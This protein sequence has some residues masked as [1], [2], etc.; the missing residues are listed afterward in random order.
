MDST[1]QPTPSNSSVSDTVS[2]LQIQ[3]DRLKK[4]RAEEEKQNIQAFQKPAPA[5]KADEISAEDILNAFS[6]SNSASQTP[7]SPALA[8]DN[9][10]DSTQAV[11]TAN[12]TTPTTSDSIPD[13]QI[14][15]DQTS[16]PQVDDSVSDVDLGQMAQIQADQNMAQPTGSL[17]KEAIQLGSNE[18]VKYQEIGAELEKDQELEKWVEEIP[19]PK[20]ITLPKPVKDDYGE[21]LVQASQIPKP[22]I[23]LPISED[24]MEKALHYKIIDSIR[25]LY[26]WA[27]RVILSQPNRVYY[28]DNK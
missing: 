7:T 6:Q 11:P 26:E 10:D 18:M 8:D 4:Q 5:I 12:L 28:Q 15:D 17:R 24:Q 1:A 25:W 14:V 23:I 19:D 3:L 27:K 9:Q 2:R 20:T 22:K 21:I 16:I 13:D